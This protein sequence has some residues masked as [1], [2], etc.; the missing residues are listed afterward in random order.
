MVERWIRNVSKRLVDDMQV[1]NVR[2]AVGWN[3]AAGTT[4]LSVSAHHLVLVF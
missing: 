4:A 1:R 3:K 2:I